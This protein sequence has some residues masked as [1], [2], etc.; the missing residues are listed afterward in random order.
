MTRRNSNEGAFFDDSVTCVSGA[1]A[2]GMRGHHV[3]GFG[4]LQVRLMQLAI[5]GSD[6][7][8]G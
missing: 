8:S 4:D 5:L 1:L 6:Y 7:R 3:T 2:V